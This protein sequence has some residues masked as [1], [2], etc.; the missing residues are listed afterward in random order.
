MGRRDEL[1]LWEG[2]G[3]IAHDLPLPLRVKVQVDLVDE[4]D[5]A[6]ARLPALGARRGEAQHEA[7]ARA[8]EAVRAVI[9]QGAREAMNRFNG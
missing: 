6:S 1:K 9:G 8:A 2:I 7:V 3:Q 4:H 5:A